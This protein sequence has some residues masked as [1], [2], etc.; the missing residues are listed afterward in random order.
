MLG[1]EVCS[2]GLFAY[3]SSHCRDHCRAEDAHHHQCFVRTACFDPTTFKL[4]S[5]RPYSLTKWL[6]ATTAPGP[7]IHPNHS[8]PALSMFAL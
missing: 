7:T 1:I 8:V 2:V 5:L 4:C 3:L 6:Q